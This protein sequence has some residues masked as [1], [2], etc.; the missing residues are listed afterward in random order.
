MVPVLRALGVLGVQGIHLVFLG[1]EVVED[2]PEDDT[3]HERGAGQTDEHPHDGRVEGGGRQGLGERGAEGVGEQVHGLHEGLHGGRGLGVGVLEAGDGGED[4]RHTDEHVRRGLDGDVDV[5]AGGLAVDDGEVAAG[6]FVTGAGHVDEVLH[7]GGVHHGQRGDDEPERDTGDGTEADVEAAQQ[8]VHESLEQGNEDDDGDGVEV[9]HQI[10]GDAVAVHLAGLGDEVTRE[11]AVDD[12]VDGIE[13]EDTAGDESPLELVDEVVV[14]RHNARVAVLGLPRRL[15]GVH[16]AVDDH[17]PQR[18]EGIGDDGSLRGAD[19]VELAADNEHRGADREHAQTEQEPGPEA[20]IPL[21]V[22]RG[23]QRERSEVDTAVE[24]HVDA[25]D[26]QRGVDDDPLT[27]LGGGHGHLLPLVL[28]GN[29]GL[30]ASVG[31]QTEQA[32]YQR[33]N[34]TLDTTSSQTDDQDGNDE[35]TQT[36]TV[37][38]RRGNRRADQDKQSN[39]VDD[40]E[41]NDGLV[42]SEVL[43][44]NDG[45]DD[46]SNCTSQHQMACAH[47]REPTIAPELEERGQTRGTLVTHAQRT[48]ALA[49]VERT[50]DVV[51]EET[52][53]SVVGEPLT[54]LDNGDQPGRDGKVFGDM[55]QRPGLV[56]GRLFTVGGGRQSLLVGIG[57]LLIRRNGLRSVN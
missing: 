49:A 36:G 22:G 10:V 2:D 20:D 52:R 28:V 17:D 44:G 29:L 15:R 48:T 33:S 19:D 27:L 1:V 45:T 12:P 50:V 16:V 4:L 55:A 25:L 9:L 34:V 18:L 37:S 23:Q 30:S 51:L 26:G 8:G 21:H 6:R 24:D 42:F 54:Q 35:T 11:L 56:V 13:G 57:V 7:D 41:E 31:I 3:G 43:I 5:V 53:H 14:P 38:Q 32:A 40:T 46:G 39:Q 47:R